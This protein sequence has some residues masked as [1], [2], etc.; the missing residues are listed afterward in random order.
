M[1]PAL[2]LPTER[3]E[4]WDLAK[5]TGVETAVVHT[6]EMGDRSRPWRYEDL[7]KLTQRFRDY[8]LDLGVIEGCLP[9]NI[10]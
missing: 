10:D 7:L 3:G 1:E 8:G 4:R 9:R 5:Q 2:V 6:L